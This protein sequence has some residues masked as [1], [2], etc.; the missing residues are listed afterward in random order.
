M[1]ETVSATAKGYAC[2]P[3]I[4]LRGADGTFS[5]KGSAVSRSKPWLKADSYASKLRA[6]ITF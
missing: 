5:V 3:D 4:R 2:P 1:A 6:M